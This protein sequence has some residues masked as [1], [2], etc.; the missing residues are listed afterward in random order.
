MCGIALEKPR[1]IR[2]KWFRARANADGAESRTQSSL[3]ASARKTMRNRTRV[4]NL[5]GF[6]G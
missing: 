2:G 4:S 5:H 6:A 1:I 3:G